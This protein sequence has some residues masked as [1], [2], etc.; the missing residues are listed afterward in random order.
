M[1]A[2]VAGSPTMYNKSTFRVRGGK[3]L[4]EKI[5][6]GSRK[7]DANE[8]SPL[9][10]GETVEGSRGPAVGGDLRQT[11]LCRARINVR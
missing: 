5:L 6:A 1:S 3:I 8:R 4:T 11:P 9:P 7:G 10:N 2:A